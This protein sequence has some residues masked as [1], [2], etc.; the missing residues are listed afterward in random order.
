MMLCACGDGA[1]V[2]SNAPDAAKS[3]I[4]EVDGPKVTE[5]RAVKSPALHDQCAFSAWAFDEDPKGTN[6][7]SGPGK[8]FPVVITLP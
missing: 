1:P 4:A 3:D 6:V 8:Q 2:N 7:R 5:A